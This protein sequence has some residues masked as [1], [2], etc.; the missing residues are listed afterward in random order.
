MLKT[1]KILASLI[2]LSTINSTYSSDDSMDESLDA[3]VNEKILVIPAGKELIGGQ[4]VE[5]GLPATNR[6]VAMQIASAFGKSIDDIRLTY[7]GRRHY[8]NDEPFVPEFG[9]RMRLV[10]ISNKMEL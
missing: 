5:I 8:F 10:N 7:N 1:N 9:E 4:I 6:E 2:I 3:L